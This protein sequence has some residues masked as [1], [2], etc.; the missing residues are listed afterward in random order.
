[1]YQSRTP[2]SSRLDLNITFCTVHVHLP[3]LKLSIKNFPTQHQTGAPTASPKILTEATPL[4][5][6]FPS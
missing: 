3:V 2:G 6:F 1:M 5:K 4:P